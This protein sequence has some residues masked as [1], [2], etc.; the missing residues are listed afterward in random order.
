MFLKRHLSSKWTFVNVQ[1]RILV[2][3][4]LKADEHQNEFNNVNLDE[5]Y[6][7][8]ERIIVLKI[9]VLLIC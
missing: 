8:H 3:V 1:H 5:Q 4:L 7:T 9:T 2:V 6:L